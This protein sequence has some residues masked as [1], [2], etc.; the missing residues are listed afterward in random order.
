MSLGSFWHLVLRIMP[1]VENY[2]LLGGHSEDFKP[3]DSISDNAEKLFQ[4][5]KWRARMYESFC[6]KRSGNHNI[7]RLLWIKE[8]QRSQVKKFSAFPCIRRWKSLGSL[9]F[10]LMC[11]S[12]SGASILCFL[13]LSLL[14]VPWEGVRQELPA[15]WQAN[16]ASNLSS[17]R[18][19]CQD[20]CNVVTWSLQHPLLTQ[21][22][23]S[24]LNGRKQAV[25]VYIWKELS[26]E[27][28]PVMMW[29]TSP[30]KAG[31]ERWKLAATM[32][33]RRGQFNVLKWDALWKWNEK[34][35]IAELYLTLF[36]TLWTVGRQ[37]P[38]SMEFSRQ[39]Y[40]SG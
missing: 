4:R 11:T 32:W 9:T 8:N 36:V 1:K 3:G 19:H 30:Q 13:I 15:R 10:P 20:G 37:V 7:K 29:W 21:H 16:S 35:L 40:W 22:C 18:A 27:K 5:G 2:V 26:Q 33:Q 24:W 17:L 28:V 14:G 38:W 6:N 34:V 31:A 25:G 23:S 12:L 39:E